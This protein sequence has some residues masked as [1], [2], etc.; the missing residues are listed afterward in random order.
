MTLIDFEKVKS[1]DANYWLTGM[2]SAKTYEIVSGVPAYKTFM[3]NEAISKLLEMGETEESIFEKY[4][5]LKSEKNW[6]Y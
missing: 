6:S 3:F 2:H 5:Q 4:K 1:K